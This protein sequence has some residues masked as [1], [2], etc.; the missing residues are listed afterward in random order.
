VRKTTLPKCNWCGIRP[1]SS[2]PYSRAMH[3]DHPWDVTLTSRLFPSGSLTVV[4]T[5]AFPTPHAWTPHD[6]GFPLLVTGVWL[7]NHLFRSIFYCRGAEAR[8]P[9]PP[10]LASMPPPP[11]LPLSMRL[12][13]LRPVLLTSQW[14]QPSGLH[15]DFGQHLRPRTGRYIILLHFLSVSNAFLNLYSVDF[16]FSYFLLL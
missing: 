9:R 8:G 15:H 13:R 7:G 14:T 5:I 11:W 1:G 16:C 12:V 3:A 10:R 2:L 6:L 4:R